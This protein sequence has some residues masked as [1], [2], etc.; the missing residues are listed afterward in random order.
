MPPL[1]KIATSAT[2]TFGALVAGEV[3]GPP[4]LL[5]HGFA[6]LMHCGECDAVIRAKAGMA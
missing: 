2:L 3:G 6:E 5:L 4:V 1:T